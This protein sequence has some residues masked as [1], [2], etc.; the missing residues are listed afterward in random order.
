[1]ALTVTV[2]ILIVVGVLAV[3]AGITTTVLLVNRDSG[4]DDVTD[5]TA[6]PGTTT[7][8]T[9]E[10]GPSVVL[11]YNVG[12][13]IADMTGPCTEINFM[14]YAELSQTGAGLHTRQFARSFIFIQG[15]TRIVL[16]TAEVQSVGIAVRREVVKRLQ[17][18]YGD[19][20]SLRN[21]IVTGTH[22]HSTPGGYLVDFLLDVSI[23]GFSRE[24]YNAY[25]EG[26]TR[27]IIRAHEN[28]VPARLFFSQTQVSDAHMNRSP[29]S[30]EFNPPEERARYT[31]NVDDTLSQIRIEKADGSLHGI[32][33]WFAVHTTS[34]NMTNLL[35]SSD[36]LGYS[37]MM[38]EKT[39]NPGMPTG[40]PAIV[41]GFFSSNLG[42]VSPN[43]RGARCEFSGDECDNQFLLCG[44]SERCYSLG[45]GDDMF[46]STRI[47]GN[48]VYNGAL[49]ALNSPGEELTSHLAVIHQFVEMPEE[50]VARYDPVT[51]TFDQSEPVKGCVP[52]MGYSFASGT[53]DGANL[54]NI[55]Q[56]TIV[57]NPLLD[58]ISGILAE[59]TPEDVQC[60]APKPILLATGRANFPLPWHPRTVSVTLIHLAGVLV[61]GVP[62]EPTTM[63]GRRIRDVISSASGV[64]TE[65]VLVS[66]LTNEYTHYVATYEEYQVQRY[67]AA[68][69]IYGPH[70]LDI[71][72]NK[73]SEFAKIAAEGGDVPPG[74]EPADYRGNTISI[75]LPVVFDGTP[76]A[77]TFGDVLQQPR[78]EVR[79][80]DT[81]VAVF[82]GAS[83]RNDL[84][85]E[86]TYLAVERL[87]V[88][89]WTV[90]A[91]DADWETRFYWQRSSTLLGSSQVTIEYRVPPAA[92]LTS[93]RIR[94]YG[95]SRSVLGNT[96]T[97]FEGV[98]N[99][100]R[101][102]E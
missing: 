94:Y 43:T 51:K 55:T 89:Q 8:E 65:K 38:M 58:T 30:Y 10:G 99:E 42:D 6:D 87:E 26:I 18:L 17:E 54:L 4:A 77:R 48:K 100:F 21:V 3:A 24:T 83:P 71:F 68:S 36:N 46:E 49:E 25:V 39:L 57:G 59:P 16:V 88:G 66:G 61:A 90:V 35:V 93:Y 1:M 44:A 53:I 86:S 102:V 96:L 27:S 52:G 85:Q 78:E 15:D 14:G 80:G 22:T 69:T 81:V 19:M 75:I 7:E 91:T 5:T 97:P 47:I 23:L 12:V 11:P 64:D 92:Y 63:S 56:G 37:A 60:H 45:P 29:Y 28:V 70:T 34:M 33:T 62:G 67:E 98:T 40:K 82:Q 13:G 101:V 32:L 31:N 79:R 84:R 95:T 74:P 41:A 72:L 76:L 50:T 9:T 2:K 20:Y 73:F